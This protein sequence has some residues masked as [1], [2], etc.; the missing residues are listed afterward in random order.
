MLGNK[1]INSTYGD[2]R[3]HSSEKINKEL[4][5]RGNAKESKGIESNGGL[6]LGMSSN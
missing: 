4:A 3:S 2:R 6:H 5:L 1:S